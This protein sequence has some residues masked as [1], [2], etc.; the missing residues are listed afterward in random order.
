[1]SS[2]VRKSKSAELETYVWLVEQCDY[3][4]GWDDSGRTDVFAHLEAANKAAE[5]RFESEC[6][7]EEPD[8]DEEED[9]AEKEDIK[10]FLDSNGCYERTYDADQSQ[11]QSRDAYGNVDGCGGFTVSVRRFRLKGV[12]PVQQSE[13]ATRPNAT[14]SAAPTALGG[15][16]AKKRKQADQQV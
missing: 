8:P 9:E 1:M 13:T 4:D 6:P 2:T 5:A 12:V 11:G 10:Q 7:D 14:S 16:Q 15:P 3:D